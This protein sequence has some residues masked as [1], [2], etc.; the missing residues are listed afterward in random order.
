MAQKKRIN[1]IVDLYKICVILKIIIKQKNKE[2][3]FQA[4]QISS[5][6]VV[7]KA[8]A[9]EPCA[10]MQIITVIIYKERYHKSIKITILFCYK[11]D[12]IFFTHIVSILEPNSNLIVE[13]F[14]LLMRVFQS[15]ASV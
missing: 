11:K 5:K 4:I 6:I 9:C 14:L 10:L 1:N 2:P 7:L 8:T 3:R 12:N 15:A 13:Y